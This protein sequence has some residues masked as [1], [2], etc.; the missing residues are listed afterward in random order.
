MAKKPQSAPKPGP[1]P[2]HLQIEGDWEEAVKNALK[3]PKP[4]DASVDPPAP[5]KKRRPKRG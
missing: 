4:A 2:E 3:R 5:P 1:V